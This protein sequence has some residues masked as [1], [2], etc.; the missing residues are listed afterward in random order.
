MKPKLPASEEEAF[1]FTTGSIHVWEVENIKRAAQ[2]DEIVLDS[3]RHAWKKMLKEGFVSDDIF[4]AVIH[5]K[6]VPPKD[7]P[8]NIKNRAPGIDF[9]EKCLNGSKWIL[10]KV[11]WWQ[12]GCYE[13]GTV[14]VVK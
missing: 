6:E 4:H 7:L 3:D 10:V 1:D 5:G 8:F 2:L 11:G 13:F 9:R 14:Y 12:L